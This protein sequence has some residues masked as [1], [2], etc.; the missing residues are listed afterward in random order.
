MEISVAKVPSRRTSLCL[1]LRL[2]N[3]ASGW[4]AIQSPRR[5]RHGNAQLA[6]TRYASPTRSQPAA[7]CSLSPPCSF[8]LVH[9]GFLFPVAHDRSWLAHRARRESVELCFLELFC[10]SDGCGCLR[11]VNDSRHQENKQSLKSLNRS[12]VECVF[13]ADSLRFH[14]EDLILH[15]PAITF[16]VADKIVHIS[17]FVPPVW[18]HSRH[19]TATCC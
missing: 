15:P 16:I 8:L 3:S 4:F 12:R 2:F 10:R 1:A 14:A 13:I 19:Q 5:R 6:T 7:V 18:T 9:R 11:Y 17:V